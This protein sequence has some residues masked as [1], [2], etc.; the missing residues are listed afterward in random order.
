MRPTLYPQ[1]LIHPRPRRRWEP[2]LKG[3]R[4]VINT[5]ITEEGTSGVEL[6]MVSSLN[7]TVG[8]ELSQMFEEEDIPGMSLKSSVSK[9]V[10]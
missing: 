3:P 2:P 10:G 1:H 7:W 8:E 9:M 6:G 5:P 4:S